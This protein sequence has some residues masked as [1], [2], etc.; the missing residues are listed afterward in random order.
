MKEQ[1]RGKMYFPYVFVTAPSFLEDFKS[2]KLPFCASLLELSDIVL[3]VTNLSHM[4]HRNTIQRAQSHSV[5][6]CTIAIEM[7]MNCIR[8]SAH[9]NWVH[10]ENNPMNQA[11]KI[12]GLISKK[13]AGVGE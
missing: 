11:L 12:K 6:S 10:A 13:W 3:Q 2:L 1:N 9:Y 8:A 4:T 5:F 7:A